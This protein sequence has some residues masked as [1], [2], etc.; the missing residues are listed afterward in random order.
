MD[1]NSILIG[2]EDP[3]RL[4]AY[5]TRLFGEPAMSD[6]SYAGWQIGSGFVSIGAHSGVTGRSAHPGRLI[7]NIET[8][9]V[10]GTF[11]R[12]RDAGAIVVAEPYELGE[13]PGGGQM[14]IATFA[15]PD[16]NY[17]QLM[18]PFQT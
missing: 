5:Y 3:A 13:V 6:E 1:F 7:W 4:V 12:F 2:P 14:W 16:E 11:A 15:D 10:Q 9:D 18:S 8:V 17:F